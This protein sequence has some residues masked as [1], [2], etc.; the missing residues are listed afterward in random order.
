MIDR[1]FRVIPSQSHHPNLVNSN[2]LNGC[3]IYSSAH[4][5]RSQSHR[6]DLVTSNS[7]G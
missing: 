7:K 6:L 4:P 2:A 3:T 5:R 1:L